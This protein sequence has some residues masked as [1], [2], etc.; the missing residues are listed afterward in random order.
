MKRVEFTDVVERELEQIL[1]HISQKYP[2]A[3]SSFETRLRTILT[4]IATW[5]ESAQEVIERPGIRR[6]PFIRYP[7]K[8]FYRVLVDR[9]EVLHVH[10]SARDENDL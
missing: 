4:R 2:S 5:P 1:Q 9:I 8:M 7:Y 10:H 6:V 3:Y